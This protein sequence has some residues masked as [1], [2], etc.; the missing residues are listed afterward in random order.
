MCLQSRKRNTNFLKHG[1]ILDRTELVPRFQ[2]LMSAF[3]I[4]IVLKAGFLVLFFSKSMKD[5]GFLL[6]YNMNETV[7]GSF[8][9]MPEDEMSALFMEIFVH[10]FL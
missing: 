8:V 4:F 6:M 10:F 3:I 1:N 5:E 7:V 9:L 2:L